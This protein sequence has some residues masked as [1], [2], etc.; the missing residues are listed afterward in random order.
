MNIFPVISAGMEIQYFRDQ[1]ILRIEVGN[2]EIAQVRR[3]EGEDQATVFLSSDN[4]VRRI[5]MRL[6]DLLDGKLFTYVP[7]EANLTT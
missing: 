5:E 7:S 3:I 1:D 4:S 6:A 2:G